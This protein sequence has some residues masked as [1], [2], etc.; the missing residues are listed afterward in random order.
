G[1]VYPYLAPKSDQLELPDSWDEMLFNSGKW[2][3]GWN[4]FF[5]YAD[6]T[7]RNALDRQ[8]K[9][10]E[11]ANVGDKGYPDGLTAD[12]AVEKLKQ[13]ANRNHPCFLA[14]G[15]FK[16][17]LLFNAPKKYWDLYD[18]SK[19]PLTHSPNIP[20]N[21]NKAS[22]NESGEF[23]GYKYGDEVASLE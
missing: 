12:L 7:N 14:V 20:Q 11:K 6:G 3:N 21:I 2:G 17:H 16:P 15:F 5:G 10:Y 18:E 22:L 1:Y 19:I 4:A 23:N 13:L 8:V 9:P